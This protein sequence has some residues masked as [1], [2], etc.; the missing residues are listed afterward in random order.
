MP[1]LKQ[2]YEFH[3]NLYFGLWRSL[4]TMKTITMINY[5]QAF[6]DFKIK[7]RLFDHYFYNIQCHYHSETSAF[8]FS[9]DHHSLSGVDLNQV[10]DEHKKLYFFNS[11][12]IAQIY[13]AYTSNNTIVFCGL[14]DARTIT[15]AYSQ[16]PQLADYKLSLFCINQELRQNIFN[17][18]KEITCQAQ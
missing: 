18:A 15:K 2:D 7:V 8:L 3:R 6:P 10:K 17:T 13:T 11:I 9:K 16:N 5:L 14:P 12:F 1:T 4:N